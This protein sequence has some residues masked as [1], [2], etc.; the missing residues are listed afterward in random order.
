MK[1]KSA[2][3]ATLCAS[4][5]ASSCVPT[6]TTDL[7]AY[8]GLYKDEVEAFLGIQYAEDTSGANRF[9]PP[10]PFVPFG[11]VEAT[12]PGPA[13]P[14]ALGTTGLP[15]Y[16]GNITGKALTTNFLHGRTIVVCPVD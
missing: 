5:Q 15:L 1:L 2:F 8:E 4:A 13:C 6:A 9:K 11:V 12:S 14:Q 7:A 3:F 16:L 10:V